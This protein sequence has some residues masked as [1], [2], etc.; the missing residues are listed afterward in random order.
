[1]ERSEEVIFHG[2]ATTLLSCPAKLSL[3]GLPLF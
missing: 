2:L 3:T 1:M